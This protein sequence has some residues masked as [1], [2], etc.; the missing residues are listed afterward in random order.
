MKLEEN[1][2]CWSEGA[3]RLGQGAAGAAGLL[4]GQTGALVAEI[5]NGSTV[6]LEGVANSRA[7]S[8]MARFT[9]VKTRLATCEVKG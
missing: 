3:A 9:M 1:E 7:T 4:D 6:D 5:T 2:N 8:Y